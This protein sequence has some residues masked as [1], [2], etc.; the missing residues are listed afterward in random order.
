MKRSFLPILAFL[1]AGSSV[2]DTT[3]VTPLISGID[4]IPIAV[5]NLDSTAAFFQRLGFALKPGRFHANGIRNQHVK[6][7]NGTELELLTSPQ[8]VDTLSTEYYNSLKEGE[9]PKFFGLFSTDM[10][11]IAKQLNGYTNYE[12]HGGWITFPQ[13]NP[14]HLLFFGGRQKAATDKP[15]HFA[16]RN[17]ATSVIAVWLAPDNAGQF[18]D[19]FQKLGTETVEQTFHSPLANQQVQLAKFKE[20][21]VIFLPASN[22]LIKHHPIIGATV[23][24]Q[25][26]DMVKA[27]LQQAGIK[28]PA[29]MNG[30]QGSRSMFLS[31]AITHN[32]WLEFRQIKPHCLAQPHTADPEK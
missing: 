2:P 26:L 11:G 9:G 1:L 24:V 28:V 30:E 5:R 19:L 14:F 17:S 15:E 3:E 22:Q 21:Q 6:F 27:S 23:Q 13:T 31:P 4:H 16:H 18:I 32:I 12:D 20:G 29:V 10:N 8:S 7:T 25:S